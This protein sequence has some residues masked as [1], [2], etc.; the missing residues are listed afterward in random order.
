MTASTP[1]TAPSTSPQV[2]VVVI[3]FDDAAHI[4]DAV[5]S[6]LAQGDSVAEV[7]VVDDA[8]TDATPE[9]LSRLAAAD[10]RVRVIT[11]TENSGG[12]GT[13][14]NQGLA[15]ARSPYVMLLDS[16]DVL[17]PDAAR[18]L[19]ET[20]VAEQA[21]V[22]AGVCVRRELPAGTDTPW[23]RD[24]FPAVGA[25]P[26]RYEGIGE[27]PEFLRDT[28]CVNKLY[29]RDFLDKHQVRFAEGPVHYE[30]FVFTARLYAARPR[31]VAV[32]D[33]VYL[34][35]VRREAGRQSISLRRDEVRNWQ[36]RVD[37]HADAVRI[38]AE[39]G[40]P[41]LADAARTKFIDHD[42]RMYV[43]ELR[44]KPAAY[45]AA[46]WRIARTHLAGFGPAP[47]LG[48]TPAGRWLSDL[49]L[50]R[51]EPVE[52]VELA[53]ACELAAA[54]PR[55]APPYLTD[56]DGGPVL[57]EGVPLTGLDE[58]P[59]AG[60][61]LAVDGTVRLGP[62]CSV[63]L[64]LHDP[65]GL[66][67]AAR[68]VDARLELRTRLGPPLTV[69]RAL[70]LA[71]HP[72]GGWTAETTVDAFE[73]RDVG[74]MTAW[75]LRVVL[76]FENGDRAATAVRAPGLGKRQTVAYRPLLRF[77]LVQAYGTTNGELGMRVADGVR[78]GWEVVRAR[79]RRVLARL[80]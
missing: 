33:T 47:L 11:R 55:L 52:G 30:D 54:P 69:R 62:V 72:D 56:D 64:R 24:L 10:P 18:A 48:A 50:A 17:A 23:Q 41:G 74:E 58:L 60:L 51:T 29:Q 26:H 37:A 6:A 43:R 27:R 65:Y 9:R 22:V 28:L 80:G 25:P 67:S 73:L 42:L 12:C 40:E 70:R 36:D 79:L 49:L 78:G 19:L 44:Q 61:P 63:R 46:W 75:S 76:G 66:V 4:A 35:H 32:G 57:V 20:A 77:A 59:P 5:R 68:P 45:R 21:E 7:I 1:G 13:P 8:S 53:R 3:V 34:W 39:A 31:L 2:S 16:D 14:R 71:P 38:L 15:A